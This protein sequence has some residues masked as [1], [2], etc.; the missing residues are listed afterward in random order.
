MHIAPTGMRAKP[1]STTLMRLLCVG[2]WRMRGVT[3]VEL[4]LGVMIVGT[5]TTISFAPTMVASSG[6]PRITIRE[7]RRRVH[8]QSSC[9]PN[10]CTVRALRV[11][12]DRRDGG[13][14][15]RAR[16]EPPGRAGAHAA[17]AAL[18]QLRE[19]AVR[20]D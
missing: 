10:R 17:C 1:A 6:S 3:L 11:A 12:A 5:L 13:V 16:Q 9:A 8:P 18:R 2:A 15:V 4:M 20:A 14:R 7:D 19:H